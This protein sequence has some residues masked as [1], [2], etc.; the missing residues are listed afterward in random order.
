[1]NAE[2][3][4]SEAIL[5]LIG[6]FYCFGSI[7]GARMI[8]RYSFLDHALD[9]ISGKPA[10]WA[11]RFRERLML[12]GLV[13]IVAGGLALMF[14]SPFAPWLFGISAIWQALYLGWFA[15]RYLDPHDDPGEEGR[16][17]T[18]RA[19]WGYLV[20]TALVL[21]AAFMGLLRGPG[22][23]LAFTAGA[24]ATVAFAGWLY[25]SMRNKLTNTGSPFAGLANPEDPSEGGTDL[26]ENGF[27]IRDPKDISVIIR[28]SWNDGS[29]FR[30]D[31]DDAVSWGWQ[32][33]HLS[34]FA[35]DMLAHIGCV[36]RK[37]ADPYDPRR[38]ALMN[39]ADAKTIEDEGKPAFDLLRQE[40]GAERVTFQPL[41]APVEPVL[42]AN[43]VK[44]EPFHLNASIWSLDEPIDQ[45][46]RPICEDEFGISW[47]LARHL[48]EWADDWQPAHPGDDDGPDPAQ[49]TWTQA[50]QDVHEERGRVLAVRL[51]RE[52]AATDRAH[53]M[54]YY[55]T[56]GVGLRE[57]H[58]DMEIP[59]LPAP[60]ANI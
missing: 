6:A 48:N 60:R 30:T 33:R 40:L 58:A 36:F 34:E 2:V 56:A 20:A 45:N 41:P 49:N 50:E 31:I 55:M 21:A 3:Q 8:T 27:K 42:T 53:V 46:P 7:I 24:V 15:P 10:P 57:A 44:I 5:R 17:K 35:R 38:C 51:K 47:S 1:M 28:P 25:W 32:E 16:A 18:W 13:P 37:V 19:F 4:I 12:A 11:E 26:P 39:P 43:R 22:G 59:P 23:L 14:L 52:L 29:L 54:V 9:A